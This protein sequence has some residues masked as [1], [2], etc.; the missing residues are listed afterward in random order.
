MSGGEQKGAPDA[1]RGAGPAP[2]GRSS[3]SALPSIG[4][5]KN[6]ILEQQGCLNRDIGMAILRLVMMEVGPEA[7]L[8]TGPGKEVNI[9][10]DKVGA[11][12]A[13][14]LG[15]IYNMVESRVASLNQPARGDAPARR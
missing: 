11:E 5:Q 8:E 4:R 3:A 9:D 12:N 2:A 7:V 1:R 15:H 10:L 6:Y 14:V 13:E